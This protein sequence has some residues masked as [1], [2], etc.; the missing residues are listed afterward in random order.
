VESIEEMV[1]RD[2]QFAKEFYRWIA[3]GLS[4]RLT[5]TRLQLLDLFQH[6]NA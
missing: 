4:Q 3:L 6:P 2:P 1:D 5:A